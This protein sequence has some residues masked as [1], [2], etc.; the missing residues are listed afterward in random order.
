MANHNHIWKC[1]IAFILVVA[2]LPAL[3]ECTKRNK[4]IFYLTCSRVYNLDDDII[5][6]MEY[7]QV[8]RENIEELKGPNK[9]S[10]PSM[11]VYCY[12]KRERGKY[13]CSIDRKTFTTVKDCIIHCAS[14]RAPPPPTS[15]EEP[16]QA[17]TT[18]Q[19]PHTSPQ[20]PPNEVTRENGHCKRTKS[21]E[22]GSVSW[23]C[24]NDGESYT[25]SQDC[26]RHCPK[27]P[28]KRQAPHHEPPE[29][30]PEAP[31]ED[32]N[33]R[34][35][36]T[37]L[38]GSST[39]SWTCK[40]DGKSYTAIVGCLRHCPTTT[41]RAPPHTSPQAPPQTPPETPP[42]A[43]PETPPKAPPQAPSQD[44]AFM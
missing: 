24:K 9:P 26:K 36:W 34:C 38:A 4:T 10:K 43:P 22:S 16:P 29:E 2:T 31:S 41:P 37:K 28:P 39:V 33:E 7:D 23:T 3:Y 19:P 42:Q 44:S 20:A 25:T 8:I 15:P 12:R 1:I 13:I 35:K 14:L 30:P 11:P 6:N 40:F 27:T 18:A 17:P 5:N 32:P 21:T